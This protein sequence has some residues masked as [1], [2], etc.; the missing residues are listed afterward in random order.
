MQFTGHIVSGTKCLPQQETS[1]AD[2]DTHGGGG[3][4]G[5]LGKG[6]EGEGGV[7]GGV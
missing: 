2:V 5:V 7:G 1:I 3:G 6:T 4:G